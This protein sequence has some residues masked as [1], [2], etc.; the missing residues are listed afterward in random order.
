MA[1]ATFPDIASASVLGALALPPTPDGRLRFS[2]DAYHRLVDIGVLTSDSRVELLDGE[3]MMMSPIGP[4]Q[5][6]IVRRLTH[7]FVKSLPDTM[8][9]SVQ[10]PIISGDHSEPEPD[11]ALLRRRDDDYR[12]SHPSPKDVLLLIEV[13][14]SSLSQD[15]GR[16]L[17]LYAASGIR[18]YWVVDVDRQVIL[19]HRDP[20]GTDYQK[21]ET[22][23]MGST[24]TPLAATD[25]RLDIGWLFR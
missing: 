3:I 4:I 18:E 24:I 6:A 9:C 12:L 8:E 2:R 16:K 22:V 10:L 14:Q 5:G 19:M 17:R 11:V 20:S 25:C 1:S 13:A 23:G 7:F 15:L 21:V